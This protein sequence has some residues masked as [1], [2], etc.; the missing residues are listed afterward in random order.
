MRN[1]YCV[2]GPSGCGK[3][4]ITEALQEKYGYKTVESY[5]TRPARYTG[6]TGHV[7][8]SKEEFD[9]L[10]P[11]C[12]Y[13]LFNGH[14]YGVTADIVDKS[15]LY[16]IDPAGIEFFKENY[17]GSKGIS[18][19]GLT[20]PREVLYARMKQRGDSDEKIYERFEHDADAFRGLGQI[21]DVHIDTRGSVEDVCAFVQE[22]IA[23]H[24]REAV[25][26]NKV[27]WEDMEEKFPEPR[28]LMSPERELEFV[29]DCFDL[30]EKEGF[31]DKFWSP[32]GDFQ[33][34]FGEPFAVVERCTEASCDVS[35]LPMWNI[36]FED[37]SVMGAYPEEIV[38]SEMRENGCPYFD[39]F[40][41]TQT[42]E[43]A[44]REAQLR[45][46]NAESGKGHAEPELC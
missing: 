4:T 9:A 28:H 39:E 44:S 25:Y 38:P 43:N 46:E 20:A 17:N 30:Y 12:A 36:R 3:T 16:V 5:T 21:V 14:E 35:A 31:S 10:G 19:I 11:L 23:F 2:V 6:E 13:T 26:D 27:G 7:F 34:R 18:V 37:G 41:L 40:S 45:E 8:V 33:E 1:I 42:V 32:Y 15:D 24:E 22:W 29:N